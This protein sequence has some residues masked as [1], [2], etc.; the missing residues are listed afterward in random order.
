MEEKIFEVG[1]KV[2]NKKSGN[3]G[4]VMEIRKGCGHDGS[5]PFIRVLVVKEPMIKYQTRWMRKNV[6]LIEDNKK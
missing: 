5:F 3:T 2:R 6:E 4:Q 1:D